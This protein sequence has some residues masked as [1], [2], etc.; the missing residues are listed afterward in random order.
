MG[1]VRNATLTPWKRVPGNGSITTSQAA[2]VLGLL[3]ASIRYLVWEGKLERTGYGPVVGGG[4]EG[5]ISIA[6]I[7]RLLADLQEGRRLTRP[8]IR[9]SLVS[10]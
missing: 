9:R 3:P 4:S 8:S 6:S 1:L 10:R 2:Q 5:L 7:N